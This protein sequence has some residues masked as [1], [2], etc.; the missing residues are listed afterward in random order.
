MGTVSFYDR[1]LS[2]HPGETCAFWSLLQLSLHTRKIEPIQTSMGIFGMSSPS[3]QLPYPSSMGESGCEKGNGMAAGS[4]T[5]V[6]SSG[7]SHVPSSCGARA[8][9]FGGVG[10]CG[11]VRGDG[12]VLIFFG[13][14][15]DSPASVDLSRLP[16]S[17]VPVSLGVS[18]PRP[19]PTSP[20]GSTNS[21]PGEDGGGG[22]GC[23]SA[24]AGG[25]SVVS[26]GSVVT[27]PEPECR[28]PSNGMLP[29]DPVDMFH[30]ATASSAGVFPY[31]H[32]ETTFMNFR[33]SKP[34]ETLHV[35]SLH[36][37][38]MALSLRCGWVMHR[39]RMGLKM[40]GY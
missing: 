36:F 40:V 6:V 38:R 27:S 5:T 37:R 14:G 26:G 30:G 29:Y 21:M 16:P 34:R 35:L 13:G 11:A 31:G 24:T 9:E 33:Q 3:S 25:A 22:G 8:G 28:A 17:C 20:S 18:H 23:A 4:T 39:E 7:N 32:R 1:F 2:F 12:A 10:E 15:V 19:A